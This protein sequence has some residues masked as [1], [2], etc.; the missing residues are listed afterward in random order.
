M[1]TDSSA[2]VERLIIV[3]GISGVWHYHLAHPA[4]FTRSLCGRQTMKTS[5]NLEQWG[6]RGHLN[7]T[8]CK[9]CQDRAAMKA[10]A[11]P[12]T[13]PDPVSNADET[14]E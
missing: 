4:T 13:P 12:L 3:E 7:E 8:W 11:T 9:R 14:K 2:T 6:S 1:T 5:M 10:P